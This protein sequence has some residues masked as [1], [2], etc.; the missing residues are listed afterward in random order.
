MAI[1][2]YQSVCEGGSKQNHNEGLCFEDGQVKALVLYDKTFDIKTFYD[3][4]AP[5]ALADDKANWEAEITSGGIQYLFKCVGGEFTEPTANTFTNIKR[6]EQL[7]DY[8][9]AFDLYLEQVKGN[10]NFIDWA[11]DN[12]Y[13]IGVIFEDNTQIVPLK[14]SGGLVAFRPMVA[15]VIVDGQKRIKLGVNFNTR[16]TPKILSVPTTLTD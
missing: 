8:T 10:E 12:E 16:L 13:G 5:P 14:K 4:S 2:T 3:D 15:P 7:R 1:I 9:Y 11:N 6:N